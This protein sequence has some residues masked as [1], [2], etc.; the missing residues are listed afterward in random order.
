MLLL[1][2]VCV[3]IGLGIVG[4]SLFWEYSLFVAD[5]L[6]ASTLVLFILSASMATGTWL[7]KKLALAGRRNAIHGTLLLTA[8]ALACIIT[9]YAGPFEDLVGLWKN[10]PALL[11]IPTVFLLL[12]PFGMLVGVTVPLAWSF[13][14]EEMVPD[15]PKIAGSL[16]GMFSL[17]LLLALCL[18]L[19]QGFDVSLMIGQVFLLMAFI[20]VALMPQ[21]P[22][23]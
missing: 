19:G 14:R 7:V 22:P 23:T 9:L 2:F 8:G 17:G 12:F 3:G 6:L 4:L 5:P 20:L 1:Y 15:L 11:R 18:S 13:V 21:S 16:S 10:A